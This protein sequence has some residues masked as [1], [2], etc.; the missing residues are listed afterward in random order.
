MHM[1]SEHSPNNSVWA[2]PGLRSC[3]GTIC[4]VRWRGARGQ[5]V[6]P[7]HRT[8]RTGNRCPG[9]TSRC[10]APITATAR[11]CWASNH[12]GAAWCWVPRRQTCPCHCRVS[13]RWRTS[14]TWARSARS[15]CPPT[16]RPGG[17]AR[18]L[19]RGSNS[20]PPCPP[21]GAG[22]CSTFSASASYHTRRTWS[23]HCGRTWSPWVGPPGPPG[24]LFGNIAGTCSRKSSTGTWCC[25]AGPCNIAVGAT[26]QRDREC[27]II[28][29]WSA[30]PRIIILLS[31]QKSYT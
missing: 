15:W 13:G 4:G 14:S 23:I 30:A 17:P 8:G 1:G 25:S 12:W 9:W 18:F 3:S 10:T 19:A 11:G 22:Y 26:G 20:T 21:A 27:Y 29:I 16:C 28:I 24:T 6:A 2:S 5:C 31:Y 7:R